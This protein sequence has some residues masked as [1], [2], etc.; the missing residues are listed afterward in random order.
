MKW[1]N[2]QIQFAILSKTG[3]VDTEKDSER[4]HRGRDFKNIRVFKLP[5]VS[6][7]TF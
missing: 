2:L 3:T 5:G 7:D 6:L 1:K 4:R